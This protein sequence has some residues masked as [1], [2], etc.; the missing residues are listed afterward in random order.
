MFEDEIAH[1][2]QIKLIKLIKLIKRLQGIGASC[3][4]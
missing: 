3:A 2:G 4:P 1:R